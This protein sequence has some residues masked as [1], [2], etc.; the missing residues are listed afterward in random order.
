MVRISISDA[1]LH[2]EPALKQA[3]LE[4]FAREPV[5][6]IRAARLLEGAGWDEAVRALVVAFAGEIDEATS[7]RRPPPLVRDVLAWIRERGLLTASPSARLAAWAARDGHEPVPLLAELA[8][9]LTD[10]WLP[11][12]GEESEDEEEDEDDEEEDEEEEEEVDEEAPFAAW[13]DVRAWARRTYALTEDAEH[14]LLF[15][16]SWNDT[17]RTHQVEIR[18][19]LHDSE[20]WIVLDATVCREGQMDAAEALE[21]NTSL[22]FALLA[23]LEGMISLLYSVPVAGLTPARLERFVDLI[24]SEADD[25]EAQYTGGAD[26]F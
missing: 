17:E 4:A 11:S 26:E 13:D 16:V 23:R 3:C 20:S 2:V 7:D 18:H 12:E 25:L 21:K 1:N 15:T 24:S 5:T 10:E 22:A 6:I 19:Y 9:A 8:E 14:S